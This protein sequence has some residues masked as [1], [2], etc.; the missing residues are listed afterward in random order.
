MSS[1]IWRSASP[2]ARASAISRIRR[3]SRY[4]GSSPSAG[5]DAEP[6]WGQRPVSLT[7][8]PAGDLAVD[9]REAV[10]VGSD[11][12]YADVTG[13]VMA[14]PWRFSQI[15]GLPVWGAAQGPE[16]FGSHEER[17]VACRSIDTAGAG[18]YR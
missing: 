7:A 2:G 4:S 1:A 10:P 18:L 5:A 17:A 6:Q 3:I 13:R 15:G 12:L 11:R 16:I 14:E 8:A 9:F